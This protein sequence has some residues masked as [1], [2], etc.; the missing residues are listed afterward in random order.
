[1]IDQRPIKPAYL[2]LIP[3]KH[4][5]KKDSEAQRNQFKEQQKQETA[6]KNNLGMGSFDWNKMLAKDLAERI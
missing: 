2:D 5:V 3:L 6:D 4:F 1:M